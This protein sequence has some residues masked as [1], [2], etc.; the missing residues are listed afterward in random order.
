MRVFIV[1]A[2]LAALVSA[3]PY[4][5]VDNNFVDEDDVPSIDL[6]QYGSSIFGV[7]SNKTGQLVATYDPSTSEMNPEELGE[8]LEGDMLIRPDFGRNGLIASSSHWPGGVVPFEIS[9]YFDANG[10]D[11]IE[12][13][14]NEYHRRTCIRFKPRTY[15][16]DYVTFTS[17]STGCWSS[18]GRIGGRQEINLQTP[19][20]VSKVGT[21]IHEMMHA[22]GFF[23]EQNRSDRD[24]F[25][26]INWNNVRAGTQ[27]NFD[28]QSSVTT[29]AYG[30]EYDYGS[31]MHYSPNAFSRNGQ[32]T[33]TAKRYASNNMG[34]RDAF[35]SADV[36]KINQMYKCSN[37]DAPIVEPK[38]PMNAHNNI[39]ELVGETDGTTTAPTSVSTANQG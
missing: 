33:I 17:D 38:P 1:V 21:I 7:P 39:N 29:T 2:C 18:V 10:M 3:A 16:R 23:H 19:G 4:P 36:A 32:P 35:S 15:E 12:R 6:S 9:G 13:A 22:L 25:V 11:L 37:V 26:F 31:V 30:V 5:S 27:S 28:K 34:Q 24:D 14:I 20:C 8:Y